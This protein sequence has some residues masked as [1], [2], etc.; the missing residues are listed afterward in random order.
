MAQIKRGFTIVELI[1]VMAIVGL[2]VAFMFVA[3]N[4]TARLEQARDAI[5]QKDT[6]E[7]EVAR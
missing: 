1:V 4:P 5:R 6:I 3:L 2:L 7:S